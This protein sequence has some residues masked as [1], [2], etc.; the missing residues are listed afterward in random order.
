MYD[1]ILDDFCIIVILNN[2][3][4]NFDTNMYLALIHVV[5]EPYQK[6]HLE[7]LNRALELESFLLNWWPDRVCR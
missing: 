3:L 5:N 6:Y 7:F 4:Q 1:E 2:I